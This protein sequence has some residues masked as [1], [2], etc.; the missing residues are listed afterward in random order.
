MTSKYYILTSD[1]YLEHNGNLEYDVVWNINRSQCIIEV[2][3]SYNVPNVLH[4]FGS[5]ANSVQ[6]YINDPIRIDE[7][8]EPDI[9]LIP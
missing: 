3:S 1:Q 5:D 8:Y 7:W 2:D 6:D 9:S 4:G